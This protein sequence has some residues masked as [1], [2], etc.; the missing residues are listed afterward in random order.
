MNFVY[1]P[2]VEKDGRLVYPYTLER[3]ISND[4]YGMA[5]I[6]KEGIVEMLK[7]KRE[8]GK[9]Q[10][11]FVVDKQ[12][13]ADLHILGKFKDRSIFNLFNHTCTRG[14]EQVLERMFQHPLTDANAINERGLSFSKN[15]EWRFRL[16]GNWWIGW[17][18]TWGYRFPLYAE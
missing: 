17:S 1:L 12:T 13:L 14:G 4:R 6:E 10:E 16:L 7:A 9:A 5:I 18:A 2:T 11:E 8:C 3:G 15:Q